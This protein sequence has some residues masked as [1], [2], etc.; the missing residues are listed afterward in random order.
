M[1][2][3]FYEFTALKIGLTA[4]LHDIGKIFLPLKKKPEILERLLG[5]AEF[6]KEEK[7]R[8]CPKEYSHH[9]TLYTVAFIEKFQKYFPEKFFQ[10]SN[11][12]KREGNTFI[13][14]SGKHHKP[15][16]PLQWI[17]TEADRL[18]SGMDR[19]EYQ[20]AK[21]REEKEY[22][23]IQRI[24]IFHN[25]FKKEEQ[26]TDEWKYPLEKFSFNTIF[27]FKVQKEEDLIKKYELL[28]QEF[29][30]SF[31][32]LENRDNPYLWAQHLD[33]LL[34]IYFTNVPSARIK[35][36]LPDISLYD[37][38]KTTS[39]LAIALYKYHLGKD[40]LKE[41][42]I[43]KE[44]EKKFL[45]ISGDFYGIQ[46]FIFDTGEKTSQ[47]AKTLRGR[48]YTVSLYTQTI[49]EWICLELGLNFL[50]IFFNSAGKF[51]IL[52]PNLPSVR[53]NL[54]ALKEE[55]NNW[56][57]QYF[58]LE[59]GIGI[60]ESE[61]SPQ[62]LIPPKLRDVW[63]NHLKK[64]EEHK[65]RRF[66]INK[67]SGVI[68]GYLEQFNTE[69]EDK[70]CPFCRKRPSQD[71]FKE[72]KSGICNLCKD[73]IFI[74]ENLVKNQRIKIYLGNRGDLKIPI[75]N[76]FQIKF[77]NK[78]EDKKENKEIIKY[79]QFKADENI[80]ETITYF[81]TNGYAPVKD[82]KIMTFEEIA[83][84]ALIKDNDG[85]RGVNYLGVLKGDIDKLG[86]IFSC[87]LP[88]KYF[89][90]SRL[91]TLS[92]DLENF[93]GLYVPF[94][95]KKYFPTIYTV[96]SGGDDFFLIGPWNKVIEFVEKFREKFKK[97]VCENEKISFSAGYAL[98]KHKIPF[99]KM[100]EKAEESLK[101][102]KLEGRNKIGIF[103]KAIKWDEFEDLM[104]IKME[105]DGLVKNGI[106][107][108]SALYKLN[109]IVE[110]AD[111]EKEFLEGKKEDFTDYKPFKWRAY[112]YYFLI[113]NIKDNKK[114]KQIIESLAQNIDIYRDKMVIPLWQVIY[115][116]RK[117]K[118][119]AGG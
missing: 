30:N 34:K 81:P 21:E 114:T 12:E 31:I 90:I 74:G 52:A 115:E 62:D 14:L 94:F 110:L 77:L 109:E 9:H 68:E 79:F 25:L 84:E 50:S 7:L 61:V 8:Y 98:S 51:H 93:F 95:I 92:R 72:E 69:L 4:L 102:A 33:S 16:T 70:L 5:K 40:T 56:F 63:L 32:K 37:H 112:L 11:E 53:D 71:N 75:L 119:I 27:P 113:R 87:G 13:N 26:L 104:K 107:S 29:I 3:N 103:E 46:K 108:K 17:I 55:I 20:I 10:E 15:E 45:L 49:A 1:N 58:Y 67:F 6:S 39:A 78:D 97:F 60:V 57:Y 66:N 105:I 41:I 88:K 2:K 28:A 18:S 65:Y 117:V 54:K 99:I 91:C 100:A 116:Y 118:E 44:D 86:Y 59:T 96:F 35:N 80:P 111:K 22:Y 23:K 47:R 38:L 36:I 76:K 43:K 64:L 19:Q 83:K 48:S 85:V 89:N 106:I 82:N 42:A 73:H 24:S 101:K